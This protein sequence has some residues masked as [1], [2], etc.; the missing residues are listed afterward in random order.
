MTYRFVPMTRAYAQVLVQEWRYEG[1][2]AVYDYRHEASHILDPRGWGIGVFAVLNQA[3]ELVGELSCEFIDENDRYTEYEDYD[4]EGLINSRQLWI[5]FG[6]RPDLTGQGLGRD[7]VSA[8]VAFAIEHCRYRGE[9]V[10]LGV[11]AFNR[12]AIKVYE[13]AGFEVFDHTVGEIAGKRLECLHMRK[14]IRPDAA[15]P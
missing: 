1:E 11:A 5:G 14:R 10:Q 13:A 4:D 3:G 8:C 9:Y 2:Y 15:A 6:L 7:F 12:R